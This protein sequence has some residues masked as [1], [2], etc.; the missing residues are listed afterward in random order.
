MGSNEFKKT[1]GEFLAAKGFRKKG[2]YFVRRGNEVICSVGI[3]RS[4]FADGY[5]INVGYF[6]DELNPLL[7]KY[8]DVDGDVRT[9]FCFGGADKANNLFEPEN[10]TDENQ[11][12]TWL[13][14]NYTELIEDTSEIDGLKR[15]LEKKPGLLSVTRVAAKRF[16][17]FE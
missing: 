4:P 16:L 7:E 14:E 5:Y 10:I 9:W 11:L 13:S 6:I 17:G 2:A 12:L 1:V 3:Q 15:L 8:S